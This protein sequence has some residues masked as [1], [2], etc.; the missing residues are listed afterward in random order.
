MA[1]T[2]GQRWSKPVC[3]LLHRT[4]ASYNKSY[5]NA[6][7]RLQCQVVHNERLRC[8]WSDISMAIN[9]ENS[10]LSCPKSQRRQGSPQV[11]CFPNAENPVLILIRRELCRR[12][13]MVFPLHLSTADLFSA[14]RGPP[15]AARSELLLRLHQAGLRPH[16]HRR[17]ASHNVA[18]EELGQLTLD[19]LVDIK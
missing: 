1:V 13:C 9:S 4:D 3:A 7:T 5:C 18:I 8:F 17:I 10:G 16:A 19:A 11:P 2:R 6:S 12:F 15:T 14:G